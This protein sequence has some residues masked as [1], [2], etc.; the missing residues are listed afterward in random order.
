ML[1]FSPHGNPLWKIC[2]VSVSCAGNL[3]FTSQ[4]RLMHVHWGEGK[5]ML[6]TTF[7]VMY[8]KQIRSNSAWNARVFGIT[9]RICF[10]NT[11]RKLCAHTLNLQISIPWKQT[12]P[13]FGAGMVRKNLKGKEPHKYVW[14]IRWKFCSIYCGCNKGYKMQLHNVHLTPV[15]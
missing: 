9:R 10:Q 5:G 14:H 1:C 13:P 3:I 12:L 4:L 2:C 15:F 11:H 8:W 7:F 6:N